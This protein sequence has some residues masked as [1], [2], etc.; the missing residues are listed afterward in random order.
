MVQVV[1]EVFRALNC[2]EVLMAIVARPTSV[3]PV[4]MVMVIVPPLP[5]MLMISRSNVLLV[6]ALDT[7]S[8][9]P[10]TLLVPTTIGKTYAVAV[11]PELAISIPLDACAA[12]RVTEVTPVRV[13]GAA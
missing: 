5:P 10:T 2:A 3:H 12:V 11:V 4:P 9:T 13:S 6:L 8:L 7:A 1:S